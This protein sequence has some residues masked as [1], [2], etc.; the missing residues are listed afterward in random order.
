M[1]I[2]EGR[3]WRDV[4]STAERRMRGCVVILN[5]LID[6]AIWLKCKDEG[7]RRNDRLSEGYFHLPYMKKMPGF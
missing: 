7:R 5:H 3:L 1:G 6:S 2:T 4:K